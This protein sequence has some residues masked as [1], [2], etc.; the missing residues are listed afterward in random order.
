MLGVSPLTF[1]R[2]WPDCPCV[3]L[4][5][6]KKRGGGHRV[7]YIMEQVIEYMKAKAKE[8]F[9]AKNEKLK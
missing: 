8:D 5:S 2:T 3:I 4:G 9:T 6:N 7:R 1:R